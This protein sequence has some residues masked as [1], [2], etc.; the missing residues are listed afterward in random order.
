MGGRRT[1]RFPEAELKR[2]E[3][4]Q[5]Q[6]GGRAY[7]SKYKQTETL[8][9]KGAKFEARPVVERTETYVGSSPGSFQERR[10]RR[11][12]DPSFSRFFFFF[13]RNEERK[14]T[15]CTIIGKS[16]G[17]TFTLITA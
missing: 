4:Y 5:E 11:V 14:N 10:L 8:C 1:S 12:L 6:G 3:V 13:S 7:Y 2:D 9:E 15:L 16:F 17:V